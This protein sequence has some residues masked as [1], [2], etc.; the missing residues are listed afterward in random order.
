M[1]RFQILSRTR[2]TST[3]NPGSRGRFSGSSVAPKKSKHPP[4]PV[5]PVSSELE[6]LAPSYLF[7]FA[8]FTLYT[9]LEMSLPT[10]SSPDAFGFVGFKYHNPSICFFTSLQC[11]LLAP[12]CASGVPEL[13][14]TWFCSDAKLP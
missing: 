8:Y 14:A 3:C 1:E 11:R 2:S 6:S 12:L 7:S 5:L 4:H 9:T 10:F 13:H